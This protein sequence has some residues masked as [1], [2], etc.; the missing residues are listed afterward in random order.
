MQARFYSLCAAYIRSKLYTY[1]WASFLAL[2]YFAHGISE[3][4]AHPD[5]WYAGLI[6]TLSSFI[7]Y[8]VDPEKR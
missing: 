8:L 7:M 2:A 1:Q 4:S 5:I 3:I 6:E